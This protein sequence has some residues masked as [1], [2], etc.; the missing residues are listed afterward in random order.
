MIKVHYLFQEQSL[1]LSVEEA[2]A[3][4]SSPRNLDAITPPEL[5]FDITH[6]PDGEAYEGHIITYH[7]GILPGVKIPWVTEIRGVERGR[8]FLD[9]QLAGPYRLWHHR[10]LFKAI[11]G[12]VK[13]TDQV[14]YALPFWPFG[15]LAHGLFVRPK[16][17]RIFAF[18]REALE[19]RFG[20]MEP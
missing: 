8:S 18:R 6:C 19:K 13:M 9:E 1:P 20:R 12:G 17:E 14:H 5:R 16:L 15:E 2:W 3:F 7:L 11:P 4:F 10:H